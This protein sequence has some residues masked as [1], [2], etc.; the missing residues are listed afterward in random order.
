MVKHYENALDEL[1][2]SCETGNLSIIN[3]ASDTK[4]R[5]K[6]YNE[7]TFTM[8]N[9]ITS[10]KTFLLSSLIIVYQIISYWI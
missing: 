5:L 6:I 7:L 9:P 2:I 8:F 10:K 1:N 3:Y 4:M